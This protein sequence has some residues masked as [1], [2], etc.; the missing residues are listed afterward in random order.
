MCGYVC[1]TFSAYWWC[2]VTRIYHKIQCDIFG[3]FIHYTAL[4]L[5]NPNGKLQIIIHGDNL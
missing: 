3:T 5:P 2:L 1:C 4:L